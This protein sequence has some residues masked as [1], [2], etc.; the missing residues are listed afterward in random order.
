MKTP[1]KFCGR[2]SKLIR[3]MIVLLV[4][5]LACL[6]T[7]AL[8]PSRLSASTTLYLIS[9]SPDS[10]GDGVTVVRGSQTQSSQ[11]LSGSTPQ[12]HPNVSCTTSTCSLNDRIKTAL[13]SPRTIGPPNLTL[14]IQTPSSHEPGIGRQSHRGFR[15]QIIREI[16]RRRLVERLCPE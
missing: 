8:F 6:L 15:F 7:V 14:I 9:S 1:S 16:I 3:S 2:A 10:D 12:I 11:I 13:S 5:T 4:V